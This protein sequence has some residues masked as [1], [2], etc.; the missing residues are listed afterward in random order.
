M[1]FKTAAERDAATVRAHK[2][3]KAY[4]KFGLLSELDTMPAGALFFIVDDPTDEQDYHHAVFE[5]SAGGTVTGRHKAF[6]VGEA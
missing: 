3:L 2:T 6:V 4:P 5:V 1:G